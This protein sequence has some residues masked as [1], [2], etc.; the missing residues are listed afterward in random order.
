MTGSSAKSA[1]RSGRPFQHEDDLR[2]LL[3]VDVGRSVAGLSVNNFCEKCPFLDSHGRRFHKA[4]LKRRYY[5]RK[6]LLQAARLPGGVIVPSPMGEAVEQYLAEVRAV[7][8]P[9]K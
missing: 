8:V 9:R 7:F 4:T 1:T 5:Q 6:A 2:L 3:H